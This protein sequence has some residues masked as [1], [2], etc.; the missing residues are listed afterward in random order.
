ME[1]YLVGGAVR[2]RLLGLGEGERDWV[3]VGSSPEAMLAAGFRQVGRD[4]PVFLH[5]ET[6]DEYALARTERKVGAGHTGFVCHAGPEVT[7]EEDLERRDLT[8][9]AI[10]MD[11]DGRIIDPFDGRADLAA[12]RLRHVS[13]AFTEDP[14]R[15]FRVARFA[16][17]MPDFEVA[18][19]TLALMASMRGELAELAA[20]RVFQEFNKALGG[21]A[22]DRFRT[23]LADAGCLDGWFPELIEH[24]I[25]THPRQDPLA[26]YGLLG[27][28]LSEPA[29]GTLA[30]RLKVSNDHARL[31]VHIARHADTLIDWRAAPAETLYA[32]ITAIRI[33]VNARWQAMVLAALA[34]LERP[35]QPFSALARLIDQLLAEVDARRVSEGLTG[36]AL[37]LA[38]DR[39]RIDW[40][41]QAR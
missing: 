14:L 36:R 13:Q 23:V 33:R 20:E 21:V 35:D 37:G 18:A 30:V 38:I 34:A 12:R 7:L 6:H 9:N 8:I 39:A 32:A 22:P 19:E 2:D 5:P 29:L 11:A 16:A 25:D 17:R 40:L 1:T 41:K 28:H 27:R 24:P 26:V 31:A 3:V 15:V 10:A 4:F